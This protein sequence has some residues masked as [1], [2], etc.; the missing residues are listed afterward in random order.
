MTSIAPSLLAADFSQLGTALCA[1]E[2]ADMLHLDIMDGRFVPNISFGPG[3]IAALRDKSKLDFDVHLMIDEPEKHILQYADAGADGITIHVESTRHIHRCISIVRQRGLRASIA[4]NPG[5]PLSVIEPLLD[6][7]DMVLIMTVN[8]GFGGQAIIKASYD[9]V[10]R[11]RDILDE[12]GRSILLQVDGGVN[13]DTAVQL[14]AC[15]ADVLVAGV[16]I[17]RSDNPKDAIASFRRLGCAG[18]TS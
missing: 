17:F 4:L 12:S 2:S 6:E 18:I 9:R 16:A 3:V 5:T 8:P 1:I 11:V 7:L 15:G 14:V 13:T 10:R